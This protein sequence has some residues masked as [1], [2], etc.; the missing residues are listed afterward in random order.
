MI[1]DILKLFML[2]VAFVFA[3]NFNKKVDERNVA[4]RVPYSS[5]Q[6]ASGPSGKEDVRKR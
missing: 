2:V 6:A 3:F 5:V 1:T 4:M